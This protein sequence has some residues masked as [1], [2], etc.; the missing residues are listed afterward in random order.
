MPPGPAIRRMPRVRK[1]RSFSTGVRLPSSAGPGVGTST[2]LAPR[3]HASVPG[4]RLR[5]IQ[6]GALA[7]GAVHHSPAS[8]APYRVKR[9]SLGAT[10][11]GLR[12]AAIW[13]RRT[14]DIAPA[15]SLVIRFYFMA[16]PQRFAHEKAAS[17]AGA[18]GH[19]HTCSEQ[20][21]NAVICSRGQEDRQ[22]Y[23]GFSTPRRRNRLEVEA[24]D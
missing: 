24:V 20:Y 9:R 13:G 1:A 18:A 10:C 4:S 6:K 12:Q 23:A 5:R 15:R 11:L 19:F 7:Q 3:M 17:D 22:S 14:Q 8:S 21:L 2:L 16:H